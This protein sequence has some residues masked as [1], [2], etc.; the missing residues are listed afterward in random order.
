MYDGSRYE[1][2]GSQIVISGD[3]TNATL[4]INSSEN[5][6][7]TIEFTNDNDGTPKEGYGILNTFTYDGTQ[8]VWNGEASEEG[9]GAE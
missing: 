5:E 6:P 9:G 3:A 4:V 2:K 1:I 7:A 8:W